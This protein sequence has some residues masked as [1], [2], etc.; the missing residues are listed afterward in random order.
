[1]GNL[2]PQRQSHQ[3]GPLLHTRLHPQR[4]DL[5]RNNL[6]AQC[7]GT[8][9]DSFVE[10]KFLSKNGSVCVDFLLVFRT[11]GDLGEVFWG[12]GAFSP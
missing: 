5:Y 9:Q 1:M 10:Q 6:G 2:G 12:C 4:R 11:E 7:P 3:T 8:L